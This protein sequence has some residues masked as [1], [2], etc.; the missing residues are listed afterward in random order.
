M[1]WHGLVAGLHR[2]VPSTPLDKSMVV[3][4]L[5]RLAIGILYN[6]AKNPVKQR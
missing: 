4:Q 2:A 6:G 1:I 5:L 3:I